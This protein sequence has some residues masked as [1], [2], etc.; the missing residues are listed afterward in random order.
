LAILAAHPEVA[1]LLLVAGADTTIND[2]Q[3]HSDAMGWAQFFKRTGIVDMIEQARAPR[4]GEPDANIT[5]R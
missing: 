3:H 1:R 4:A 5:P 2:S